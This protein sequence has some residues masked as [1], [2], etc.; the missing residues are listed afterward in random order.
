MFLHSSL[1][2]VF[3]R[4]L[5]LSKDFLYTC[6]SLRASRLSHA[7]LHSVCFRLYF[8]VSLS[9][10][11]T[12]VSIFTLSKQDSNGCVTVSSLSVHSCFIVILRTKAPV[13]SEL[14]VIDMLVEALGLL[15]SHDG[16]QYNIHYVKYDTCNFL[17]SQPIIT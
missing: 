4:V 17:G 15:A 16:S 8:I 12:E 5:L 10:G 9:S 13:R 14:L 7:I 3:W 1:F 6:G 2:F 11:Y